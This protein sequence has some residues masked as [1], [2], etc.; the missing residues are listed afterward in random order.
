MEETAKSNHAK[1]HHKIELKIPDDQQYITINDNQQSTILSNFSQ[2]HQ[3]LS[4]SSKSSSN[5]ALMI[6]KPKRV[7]QDRILA[8][9]TIRLHVENN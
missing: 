9:E 3:I 1:S 5:E 6:F 4:L 8:I 2:P 7:Q